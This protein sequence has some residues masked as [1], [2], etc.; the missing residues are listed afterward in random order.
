VSQPAV[1]QHLRVLKEAQLVQVQKV[2]QQRI[3][4]VDP[5]GLSELRAYV[6]GLWEDA[7]GSFKEAAEKYNE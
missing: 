3:Y 5:E 2:G 6:E 4:R 1:S 7:L